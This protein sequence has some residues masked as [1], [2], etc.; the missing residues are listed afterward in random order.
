MVLI[1][2]EVTT[3]QLDKALVELISIS[4]SNQWGCPDLTAKTPAGWPID[5]NIVDF[6]I[7]QIEDRLDLALQG[8]GLEVGDI[9]KARLEA[10]GV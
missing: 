6:K 4:N 8:T 3:H 10:Y 2:K 7:E 5:Q 1:H 9:Q